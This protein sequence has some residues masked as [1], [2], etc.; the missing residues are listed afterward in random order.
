VF[1]Y[2]QFLNH[3]VVS[4]RIEPPHI[5]EIMLS[6]PICDY[7]LPR[8]STC[9]GSLHSNI[10]ST[11]LCCGS[12]SMNNSCIILVCSVVRPSLNTMRYCSNSAE[13]NCC[14]PAIPSFF[15]NTFYVV[16]TAGVHPHTFFTSWLLWQ[17]IKATVLG[18]RLGGVTTRAILGNGL[19]TLTRNAFGLTGLAGITPS[20]IP[21]DD[22]PVV[23]LACMT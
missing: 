16:A 3:I 14:T 17:D 4:A 23:V 18:C 15:I 5:P 20:F 9:K 2:N 22:A 21:S 10:P 1:L 11:T 13:S 6:D 7:G 19:L 12:C 8:P